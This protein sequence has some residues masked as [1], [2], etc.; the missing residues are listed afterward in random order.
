MAGQMG[1]GTFDVTKLEVTEPA[2]AD[3]PTTIIPM[4]G[5]FD[6]AATFTGSGSV[7]NNLKTMGLQYVVAYFV[8]GIGASAVEKDL[9]SKAGFLNAATNVY[10]A[11]DTTLEVPAASNTLPPGVYRVACTV[12]FPTFPGT[13]GFYEDLLIQI[14]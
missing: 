2:A 7:W 8:E 4:G 5:A 9:G 12:T 6:L 14:Y 3:V 13:T 11:P 1:A 10:S